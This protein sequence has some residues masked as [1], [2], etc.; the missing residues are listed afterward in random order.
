MKVLGFAYLPK[1]RKELAEAYGVDRKTLFRWL[2]DLGVT[3][4]RK[5]LTEPCLRRL[6]AAHG[7]PYERQP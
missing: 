3:A 6:Y 5:L 4:D 2:L 1:T 7:N